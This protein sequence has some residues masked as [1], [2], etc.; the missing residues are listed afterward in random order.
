M[1]ARINRMQ[2]LLSSYN[3]SNF[4][5]ADVAENTDGLFAYVYPNDD[6]TVH[7]GNRFASAPLEG[8]DSQAGALGHEMSHFSSVGGTDDHAY[9][10]ADSQALAQSD[11]A[12]ALEN[13]DNFEYYLENAP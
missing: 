4:R 7:L 12:K 1:I 13:A 9:G 3:D 8:T 10:T 6:Q 2:N 5:G 11:S